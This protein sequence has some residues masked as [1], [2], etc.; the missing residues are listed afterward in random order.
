MNHDMGTD[1]HG[2]VIYSRWAEKTFGPVASNMRVAVR[3][4]EEMTE[5]LLTAAMSHKNNW[6]PPKEE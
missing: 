6:R 2:T 3:A 4:Q 5:L 1:A